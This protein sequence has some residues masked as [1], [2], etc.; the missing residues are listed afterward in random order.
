[1]LANQAPARS[2]ANV[3][4]QYAPTFKKGGKLETME[5]EL[6]KD[7]TFRQPSDGKIVRLPNADY[8]KDGGDNFNLE[9]GT[10]VLGNLIDPMTK[11]QFKKIGNKISKA[12]EKIHKRESVPGTIGAKTDELNLAKLDKQYTEVFD[13]Q[14]DIRIPKD[15]PTAQSGIK[16]GEQNPYRYKFMNNMYNR[17]QA[18]STQQNTVTSEPFRGGIQ[19][20][21]EGYQQWLSSQ[22]TQQDSIPYAPMQQQGNINTQPGRA[23]FGINN[24][25]VQA[26]VPNAPFA[27]TYNAPQGDP[28][29]AGQ[30]GSNAAAP[31]LEGSYGVPG[32]NSGGQ[33]AP[34]TQG[35]PPLPDLATATQGQLGDAFGRTAGSNPNT[36]VPQPGAA[37]Q[38]FLQKNAGLLGGIAS[39][40]PVAY[41]LVQ[42]LQKRQ[43]LNKA[44]YRNPQYDSAID[45]MSNRRFDVNPIL[46][47][48]RNAA[49]IARYNLQNSG[50]SAGQ[51]FAGVQS[52]ATHRMRADA[53]ARAN[54]QNIDLRFMGEEA[55]MR[56]GLGRERSMMDLNI[57]DLNDRNQAA[58][59][60]HLGQAFGD[61]GEFGQMQQLMYN[62]K[63]QS[64]ELAGLYPDIYG[65]ILPY[66]P[67]V[68]RILNKY[69]RTGYGS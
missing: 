55:Q 25:I 33:Q 38:G 34:D 26:G 56:A 4:N 64:S 11:Q 44:D 41:N 8:H 22:G 12:Q 14:E 35:L 10:E 19:P 63:Q 47:D 30:T 61:L 45:L 58:G 20:S 9:I 46:E 53:S 5:V 67:G 1:L 32:Y 2:S 60:A 29:F 3:V 54:K 23:S 52:L 15:V 49:A 24:P 59:R 51:Q 7:E 48:N 42:G 17:A 39:L 21:Y 50:A 68:Q 62:Q 31:W 28:R 37:G 13:R 36:V 40:A 16:V 43:E 65:Q 69:N 57:Q 6:E 27:N 66:Q 18:D